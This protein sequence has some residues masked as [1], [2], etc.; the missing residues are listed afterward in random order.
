MQ[1]AEY[2]SAEAMLRHKIRSKLAARGLQGEELSSE[3]ERM[4]N[5][6]IRFRLDLSEDELA[7]ST[8]N[9]I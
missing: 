9:E 1:D 4:M 2:E 7:S 6:P 5:A 8:S 3:V